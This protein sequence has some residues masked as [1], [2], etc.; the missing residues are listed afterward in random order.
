MY[1]CRFQLGMVWF[2]FCAWPH[3][4]CFSNASDVVE[5]VLVRF[6][7]IGYTAECF[8][9]ALVWMMY[10][11]EAVWCLIH[12]W[13]FSLTD[14]SVIRTILSLSMQVEEE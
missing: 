1:L 6:A 5:Q 13:Q 14:F 4:R 7:L 11:A 9:D 10:S 8:S 2:V 12:A 3:G